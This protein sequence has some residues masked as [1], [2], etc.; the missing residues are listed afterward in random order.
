MWSAYNETTQELKEIA[1][2]VKVM[3]SAVEAN[4]LGSLKAAAALGIKRADEFQKFVESL[5]GEVA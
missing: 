3:R 4:R 5:N 2:M 1:E